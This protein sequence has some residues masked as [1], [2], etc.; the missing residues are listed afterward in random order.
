MR[1]EG[2][3]PLVRVATNVVFREIATQGCL[4]DIY[5][6]VPFVY[7]N[8][9][10]YDEVAHHRGP[11][12]TYAKLMLRSHRSRRCAASSTPPSASARA[13]TTSS[14]SAIT[15]SRRPCRGSICTDSR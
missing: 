14:C 13:P 9:S 4:L 1:D 6:G 3:F 5:R 10:G 7:L 12:S 8:Y 15:A 11:N 2:V